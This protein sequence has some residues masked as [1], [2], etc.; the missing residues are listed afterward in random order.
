[1]LLIIRK[2]APAWNEI[3]RRFSENN[4][5]VFGD[6]NLS[7]QRITGENNKFSPGSGGWPTIRYFNKAT[8]YDGAPYTKKT[9]KSMCDELGDTHYMEQY[10]MEAGKTSLCDINTGKG[11]STRELDYVQQWKSKSESELA[12]QI[13]R[14]TKMLEGKVKKDLALWI[15]QRIAILNRLKRR[16]EL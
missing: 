10:I 6:I 2:Q 15:G 14:L 4:D 9:D 5:V 11:C 8:G 12:A 1:M 3:I 7:E 13:L 16:D